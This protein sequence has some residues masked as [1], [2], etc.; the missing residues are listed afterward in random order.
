MPMMKIADSL[1]LFALFAHA[2]H[3]N[4]GTPQAVCMPMM[5]IADSLRR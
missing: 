1:R 2:I 5:K 4:G 3:E